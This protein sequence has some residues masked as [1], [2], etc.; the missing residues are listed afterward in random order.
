MRT[1]GA[2]RRRAAAA[3]NGASLA[4]LPDVTGLPN[5]QAVARLTI[6]GLPTEAK[7]GDRLVDVVER[8]PIAI[9][10]V[11]YHPQLGA[12]QTCDTCMVEV[13]GALVRACAT[14]IADGM[15]VQTAS[16]QATAAQVE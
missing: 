7:A 6:D 14:V 12:I 4:R 16:P 13:N 8:M 15:A 2:V 10:H 1:R 11:C 9:P 3:V 5:E